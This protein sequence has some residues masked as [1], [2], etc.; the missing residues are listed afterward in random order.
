[1]IMVWYIVI[2][3]VGFVFGLS[4]VLIISKG[5]GENELI[6]S[7]GYKEGFREGEDSGYDKGYEAA[8][9]DNPELF[10]DPNLI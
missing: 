9:N 1:M 10:V 5:S 2:F 8:I 4:L 6:Y 7:K 3:I